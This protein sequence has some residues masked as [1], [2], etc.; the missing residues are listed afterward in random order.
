M[1]SLDDPHAGLQVAVIDHDS[2][3]EDLVSWCFP[4]MSSVVQVY[5]AIFIYIYFLNIFFLACYGYYAY[6]LYGV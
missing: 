2:S 1:S 3:G 5:K 4:T 6:I